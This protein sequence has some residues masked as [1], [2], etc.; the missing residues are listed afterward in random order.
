MTSIK[1]F[2]EDNLHGRLA[3]VSCSGLVLGGYIE[4]KCKMV[5][6]EYQGL[7]LYCNLE[8]NKTKL[9]ELIRVRLLE[10]KDSKETADFGYDVFGDLHKELTNLV[11]NT[12]VKVATINPNHI[13][14]M[15][16]EYVDL[17]LKNCEFKYGDGSILKINCVIGYL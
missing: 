7:E 10:V 13:V 9:S 17:I 8:F 6:D 5:F 15:N 16:V 11:N 4:Q 12:D 1:K 14:N 2:I 3:Y